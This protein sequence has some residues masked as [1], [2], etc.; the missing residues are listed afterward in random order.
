VGRGK[1]R[2]VRDVWD[3][4][5]LHPVAAHTPNGALPAAVLF[6]VLAFLW[7]EPSL[8]RA[9]FYLLVLVL[10]AVPVSAASGARDWKRRYGGRRVPV[11]RWKLALSG[12]LFALCAAAVALRLAAPDL[13]LGGSPLRF[14]YA[15]LI[16]LAMVPAVLLGHFGGKLVFHW[17]KR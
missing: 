10:G 9:A 8:E 2:F 15:G 12:A 4:F 16:F 5:L 6:L 17:K 3:T 7:R 13:F 11:F 1:A 14:L